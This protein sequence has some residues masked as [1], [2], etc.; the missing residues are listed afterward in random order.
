MALSVVLAAVERT[1]MQDQ[2]GLSRTFLA[3][4]TNQRVAI[5][6]WHGRS[7]PPPPPPPAPT[8]EMVGDVLRR[9]ARS[10]HTHGQSL[11]AAVLLLLLLLLLLLAAKARTFRSNS[12]AL[13]G[14]GVVT[15]RAGTSSRPT[16]ASSKQV[17]SRE[18]AEQ[19][20]TR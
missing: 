4:P 11:L 8:T 12:G 10:G 5:A 19:D 2:D 15:C 3:P 7:P 16:V 9:Q 6:S 17:T 14:L 20:G 13:G 18:L 1:A